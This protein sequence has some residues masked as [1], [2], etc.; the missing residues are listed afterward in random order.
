MQRKKLIIINVYR[1]PDKSI[2]NFT[3]KITQLISLCKDTYHE[4]ELI[5]TGDMNIDLNNLKNPK[6]SNYLNRL[7]SCGLLPMILENTR[8]NPMRGKAT[9]LD[10]LFTVTNYESFIL[11]WSI[12]DHCAI[13][14]NLELK[15]ENLKKSAIKK[16]ITKQENYDRFRNEL[17]SNDWT[18]LYNKQ[19]NKEEKTD[20]FF[21]Q[22]DEIHNRCFPIKDISTK[23][24]KTQPWLTT[25][26]KKSI[27][28]EIKLYAAL[29]KEFSISKYNIH[30]YYKKI[31]IKLT[32]LAYNNFWHTKIEN[33]GRNSKK[34][35]ET[36]NE[37]LRKKGKPEITDHFNINNKI[38]FDKTEIAN[39]LNTYFQTIGLNLAATIKHHKNGFKKY[40][41]EYAK[42]LEI[43][44]FCLP[45]M[46]R[47]RILFFARKMNDKL[48]C[49]PDEISSK[50]IKIAIKSIPEIFAEIVNIS[51]RENYVH[52]RFKDA[53][54]CPIYKSEEK[55]EITNYRPIA[56]LNSIS[57]LLEKIVCHYLIDHFTKNDLL[58]KHQYGFRPGHSVHHATLDM[59]NKIET[60]K[61]QKLS[62]GS[63]FI[64]LSK[65][66]DTLD[67]EILFNKLEKYGIKKKE[68]KWIQNYFHERTLSTKYHNNFSETKTLK[69]GVPQGSIL[70]PV[71]FN[72]Y[73]NDIKSAINEGDIIL[74]ADDTTLL[75]KDET[76]PVIKDKM[77]R[78][79]NKLVDWFA[80]NK[81]SMNLK[82]KQNNDF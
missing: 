60:N 67:H 52:K 64:D 30:K 16:R 48:S 23:K 33:C 76:I 70:G 18:F 56:L 44:P 37:I 35:W 7:I 22:L 50:T 81:L 63:L 72:I 3:E 38:T 82:K 11:P 77:L 29:R 79:G 66:F 71:L 51:F 46:N 34:K 12:T 9:L 57:K 25:G 24:T 19:G 36:L 78:E 5:V 2:E 31:L 14:I 41:D 43:K 65:A 20:R 15:D 74:Y 73:V 59:I 4:H 49:G 6:I 58:Y 42:K 17:I 45:L 54:I 8:L 40:I 28:N 55:T 21:A 47:E 69:V 53:I 75:I 26:L 1:P 32:R 13:G 68:L 61:N 27:K 80:E 10:H 39:G 62:T